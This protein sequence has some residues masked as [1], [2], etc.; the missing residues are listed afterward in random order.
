MLDAIQAKV[1]KLATKH[2][3]IDGSTPPSTRQK[4][5]LKTQ[6]LLACCL[7]KCHVILL[8]QA[9]DQFQTD[10]NVRVAILS[11]TACGQGITLTAAHTVIFAE[12]YWVPGQMVQA[13]DRVHRIGQDWC[14]GRSPLNPLK[15]L[16]KLSVIHLRCVSA[17]C[18]AIFAATP[19]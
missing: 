4:A 18:L 6:R 5:S 19:A 2:I 16:P 14:D 9:V 3:R 12:L 8:A 11:I 13:E 17:F 10:D 15:E 1:Q 7:V